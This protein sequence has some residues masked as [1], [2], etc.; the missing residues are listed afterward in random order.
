MDG[1]FAWIGYN[2][3]GLRAVNISDKSN[4]LLNEKWIYSESGCSSLALFPGSDTIYMADYDKGLIAIDTT[5]KT[6]MKVD[7]SFDTTA[8]AVAIDISGDYMFAVDNI[9]GNMPGTEGLRILK[10][11]TLPQSNQ[12]ELTEFLKL[13]G[14]CS[15]PGTARDIKVSRGYAYVADGAHGLQIISLSDLTQPVITGTCDTPG[16]AKSLFIEGDYGFMA[17]GESG[18]CILNIM[19]KSAPFIEGAKSFDGD[20]QHVVVSDNLAYVAAGSA[21]LQIIDISDPVN[22]VLIAT[23]G[24]P[25]EASGIFVDTSHAHAFVADGAEGMNVF[26]ITNPAQPTLLATADTAGNA[27]K[28]MVS[29]N[30]AYVADGKNGMQVFD[31]SVPAAPVHVPEWSYDSPGVAM[32]IFSG[33]SNENEEL[34]AFIADGAAGVI[35]ISLSIEEI[36]DEENNGGSS[37]SGGCFIGGLKAEG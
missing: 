17:D 21:G 4:P 8:D 35:G 6:A 2:T 16:T 37:S 32:D 18:L 14:F 10:I 9:Q 12:F 1:D 15:T 26:D 13:T 11:T 19:D 29:G 22:P 34:Y 24:T 7:A 5:D 23:A 31:V 20:A 36:I 25:G 33:F 28:V 3:T 27:E 30:F